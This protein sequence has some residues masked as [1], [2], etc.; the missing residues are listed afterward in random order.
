MKSARLVLLAAIAAWALPSCERSGQALGTA[1]SIIVIATDSVWTAV[2]DSVLSA[3]EPRIYTVRSERTFEVTQIS[4]SDPDWQELRGFR[5]VVAIGAPDDAWVRPVFDQAGVQPDVS[6]PAVVT[7][8]DVWARNQQATAIALPTTNDAAA[9]LPHLERVGA[10]IDSLFRIYTVQR[11]YTSGPDTALR[12]AFRETHGFALLLPNV[13]AP[14]ERTGDLVLF[15]NNTT[16]GGDLAR[17][18]LVTWRDG[19]TPPSAEAALEWR[20]VMATEQYNP[21]Q[22]T[23]RDSIRAAPLTLTSGEPAVEV[24]GAWEGTDPAWPMGGLFITRMIACEQ[25]NRTY[26]LDTWLYAPGPRRSKYEYMIQL[27]TILG[28]FEC[29]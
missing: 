2:G 12:R 7:T 26:L 15:Q 20:D 24:Q 6:Q 10:T 25:Q 19:V 21:Q 27:Q 29:A 18:V 3:L 14:L 11:M 1:T 23:R 5:Q 8:R 28:T 22:R 16:V 17:S 9:A 13:Y 4:P